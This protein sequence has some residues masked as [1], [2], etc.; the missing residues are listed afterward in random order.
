[1]QDTKPTIYSSRPLV[2]TFE[3]T[4]IS[5]ERTE[6][7]ELLLHL[8]DNSQQASIICGPDGIG[9]STCLNLIKESVKQQFRVLLI[10]GA[11]TQN[12]A[13]I[14]RQLGS[15]LGAIN[16]LDI[17]LLTT[18]CS[19]QTIVLMIDD[20]GELNSGVIDQL[21]ALANQVADF[22]LILSMTYDQFH[23]KS[24]SDQT[25]DSCHFIELPPLNPKQCGDFL[26]TLALQPHAKLSFNAVNETLIANVYRSCH[27]IPG[28]I[29]AELPSF[30][31]QPQLRRRKH[32]WLV[33]VTTAAVIAL[34][35]MQNLDM[36]FIE[37]ENNEGT[38]TASPET[39]EI[40]IPLNHVSPN[41]PAIA[42]ISPP[43]PVSP[44]AP[45]AETTIH[46]TPTI[47]ETTEQTSNVTTVST[48]P[49]S[50]PIEANSANPVNNA[51]VPQDA[52]TTENSAWLLAQPLDNYTLQVMVLSDK[53]SV[54][55]F[56]RKYPQF[57]SKLTYYSLKKN[58]QQ[59]YV[60]I[61]GS[62]N[63]F[64]EANSAK[65][66]MPNEFKQALERRF[67]FVLDESRLSN[68]H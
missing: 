67:R 63:S 55:R 19:K 48:P 52:V 61:Y 27:G 53:T 59:K 18:Y 36:K 46:E 64:S 9:K 42:E 12:F 49:V 54:E 31:N 4:L 57:Q 25:I 43:A 60:V 40:A 50:N 14:M 15:F 45:S 11:S 21:L 24:I 1:M 41:L 58:S 39:K 10:P 13:A 5:Q 65:S 2:A 62:F 56:L 51:S 44:T 37:L 68:L 26:Q 30:N 17:A 35:M 33:T 7:L 28:K 8:L 22:K 47:I 66:Q 20:A 16:P 38:F 23:I 3:R 6:K 29:V 34:A 32:L